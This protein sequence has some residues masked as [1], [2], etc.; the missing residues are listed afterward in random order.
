MKDDAPFWLSYFSSLRRRR[1]NLSRQNPTPHQTRRARPTYP[2]RLPSRRRRSNWHDEPNGMRLGSTRSR[3]ETTC[4]KQIL[5]GCRTISY[6]SGICRCNCRRIWIQC[7]LSWDR[8][9]VGWWSMM[10]G[11]CN[12]FVTHTNLQDYEFWE[13]AWIMGRKLGSGEEMAH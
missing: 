5:T 11:P 7:L 1:Q 13:W 2:P 10:W 3:K 6:D 8:E 4:S 12:Y 9:Y